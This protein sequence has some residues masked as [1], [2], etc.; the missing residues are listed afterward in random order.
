MDTK[1]GVI[2]CPSFFKKVFTFL[3]PPS[4]FWAGSMFVKNIKN[5]KQKNFHILFYLGAQKSL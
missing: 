1:F 3:F 4:Y 2:H 5:K